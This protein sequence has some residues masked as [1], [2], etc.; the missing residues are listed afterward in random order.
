V[1]ISPSSENYWKWIATTGAIFTVSMLTL[2]AGWFV[3]TRDQPNKT[4]I[5]ELRAEVALVH[6]RQN[7][8]LVRLAVLEAEIVA[9]QDELR[10]HEEKR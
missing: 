10:Q 3:D 4:Q 6:D 8:V 2:G 1:N 7:Q 5:V 9:L